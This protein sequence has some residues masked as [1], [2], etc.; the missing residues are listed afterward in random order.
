M[1][2]PSLSIR[3]VSQQKAHLRIEMKARRALLDESARARA[4]WLACE[5]LSDW[6][7]TRP[8]TRIA[9][10]LARPFELN[11]DAL[12]RELLRAGRVVCAPRVNVAVGTMNFWQ[13]YTIDEVERGPWGVREPISNEIVRPELALVPALALDEDGSRLG[14]GGGWYDRVLADV[15]VKVGVSFASQIVDAVPVEPHDIAL[16]WVASDAGVMRCD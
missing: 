11:L 16:D 13:L 15:P 4:S 14:T 8:E 6:L 5:N 7:Q 12:A 1:S 10:Y 9:V 2:L 3:D